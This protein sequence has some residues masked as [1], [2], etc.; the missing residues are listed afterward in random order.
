M[1]AKTKTNSGSNESFILDFLKGLIVSILIS[2]A[3]VIVFALIL[4]WLDI[5]ES[6]IIPITF[7]IKYIS[8]IFGAMIAIKGSS[9]GLLKGSAFGLAYIV[10][11]FVV[12][13]ILA[14]SFIFDITTLL[15]LVS[16][17]LVGAIVGVIKVNRS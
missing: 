1:L 15:D 2:L 6:V 7:A 4:N 9:K 12:F 17:V 5:P 13:S 11:A 8:V 3:L 16:S 14:K 10:I